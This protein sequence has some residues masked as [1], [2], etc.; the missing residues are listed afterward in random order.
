MSA[1]EIERP[2]VEV[3]ADIGGSKEQALEISRW[4]REQATFI[5]LNWSRL[6]K[7]YHA[8]LLPK[9]NG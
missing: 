4:L 9:G 6:A 7:K 2:I 5:E 3:N 1:P 8:R